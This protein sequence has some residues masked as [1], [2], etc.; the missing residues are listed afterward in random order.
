MK[1]TSILI[2]GSV[3]FTEEMIDLSNELKN[4]YKCNVFI[5]DHRFKYDLKLLPVHSIYI[6]N[7]YKFIPKEVYDVIEQANKLG[8]KIEYIE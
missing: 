5:G 3:R 7:K 8:I 4:K 2:L 6:Y 1:R